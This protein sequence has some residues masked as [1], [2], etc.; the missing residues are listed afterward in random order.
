MAIAIDMVS[1]ARKKKRPSRP[2]ST[3]FRLSDSISPSS[4]TGCAF[5]TIGCTAACSIGVSASD[6][7]TA[8]KSRAR[9][10][11]RGD[12]K[13]GITSRQPPMRQNTMK[14]VSTRVGV[15]AVTASAQ[16]SR[17]D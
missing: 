16:R 1:S 11:T 13:P 10:S 5:S 7:A 9:I 15:S 14:A 6:T 4:V 12:E 8:T 3:P 17:C 2:I